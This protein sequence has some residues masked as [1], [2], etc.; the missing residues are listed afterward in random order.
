MWPSSRLPSLN[1][2]PPNRCGCTAAPGPR[3]LGTWD[4]PPGRD[5][6]SGRQLLMW[7][8][9]VEISICRPTEVMD[10]FFRNGE[11]DEVI[12]VHE[13]S[14]TVETTFGDLPYSPGDYIV[15]P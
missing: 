13:G 15:V 12:F 5:P 14:G 9:D 2:T 3:H 10:A 8:N 7:N 6:I 11:G 1:S 4:V